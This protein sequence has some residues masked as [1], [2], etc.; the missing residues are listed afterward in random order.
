MGSNEKCINKLEVFHKTFHKR[1]LKLG[2]STHNVMIYGGKYVQNV[3]K[4]TTRDTN[5]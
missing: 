2:K 3:G 1:I 5:D 4:Y